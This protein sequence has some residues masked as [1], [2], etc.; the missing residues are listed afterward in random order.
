MVP[1]L[2]KISADSSVMATAIPELRTPVMILVDVSWEDSSGL[3]HSDRAYMED[4]SSSGACLRLKNPIPP[5]SKIGVQ[6]R[7]DRFAGIARNC[8]PE[9]HEYI[10]GLRRDSTISVATQPPNP[11]EGKPTHPP[12]GQKPV[13]AAP[14]QLAEDGKRVVSSVAS[15]SREPEKIAVAEKSMPNMIT[16]DVKA[17]GPQGA[18]LRPRTEVRSQPA[19]Q[20]QPVQQR[21]SMAHKWLA[22]ALGNGKPSPAVSAQPVRTVFSTQFEASSAGSLAGLQNKNAIA[23]T[24]VF[25]LE[26]LPAEEVCRIAGIVGPRRGYGVP[27]IVEMLKNEHIRSMSKEGKRAALLMALDAAGVTGEEVQADAKARQTALDTYESE[28]KKQAETEWAR[29]TE[30]IAHVKAELESIHAQLISIQAQYNARMNRDME[31]LARDK[32]R[33]H[34]WVKTKEQECKGMAEAVEL[35]LQPPTPEPAAIPAEAGLAATAAKA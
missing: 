12:T 27:K 16:R 23:E 25:Q 33:L 6:W 2:N 13:E 10:V 28:L 3:L 5:G 35:C 30:E 22:R 7:F 14:K 11:P 9:G 34:T 1:E 24:P 19:R 17:S 21:M 18:A 4:K 20:I 32:A 8:R 29:K 26:L 31:A 15:K